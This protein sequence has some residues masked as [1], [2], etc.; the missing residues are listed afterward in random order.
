MNLVDCPSELTGLIFICMSPIHPIHVDGSTNPVEL[1]MGSHTGPL[2]NPFQHQA[3]HPNRV[4][5][6]SQPTPATHAFNKSGLLHSVF[7][8]LQS[9]NQSIRGPLHHHHPK[10]QRMDPFFAPRINPPVG[11]IKSASINQRLAEASTLSV[12]RHHKIQL[13][14]LLFLPLQ[15][16]NH[17]LF[18]PLLWSNCHSLPL[19]RDMI[20]L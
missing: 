19:P 1:N 7:L 3:I 16:S 13:V 12:A 5:G 6:P 17:H 14:S 2:H 4:D 10:S 11:A 20:S 9:T 15:W 8:C 18:L